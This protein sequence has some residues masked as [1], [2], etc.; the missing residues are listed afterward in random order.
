M[1]TFGTA[2]VI[3]VAQGGGLSEVVAALDSLDGLPV[4]AETDSRW[5]RVSAFLPDVGRLA[6]VER[7]ISGA[8][9]CRAAVAEDNDEYGA[10][11]VV[12]AARDGL[13][14][15]VHRR[16]VLNADPRRR[17]AVAAAIRSLDGIDPRKEDV[18]GEPA[19]ASAA[20]LFDVAPGPMVEAER[21]SDGL[22]R[23]I[24]V[25]GGPFPWWDA[26]GLRWPG[27]P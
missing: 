5:V 12:L 10:L 27:T 8:G 1:S 20:E 3:D 24:G 4:I 6:L 21:G 2:L 11:W 17:R 23:S 16:Y 9:E 13:V 18:A 7:V 22:Y 14:R 25:V 15:T 26:L 19:A